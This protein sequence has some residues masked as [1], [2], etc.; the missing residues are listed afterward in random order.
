MQATSSVSF[1]SRDVLSIAFDS[2]TI[3][4]PRKD[5]FCLVQWQASSS[6]RDG[7]GGIGVVAPPQAIKLTR[8]ALESAGPRPL[9]H[10]ALALGH[11]PLE[12][13]MVSKTS[14]RRSARSIWNT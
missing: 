12:E 7:S 8:K 9:P 3:G 14:T 1:S 10:Q 5:L 13:F 6:S 11:D 2:A 4:K